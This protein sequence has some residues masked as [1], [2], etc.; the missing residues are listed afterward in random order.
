MAALYLGGFMQTV[1]LASDMSSI[2]LRTTVELAFT[3][4]RASDDIS[5]ID[6]RFCQVEKKTKGGPKRSTVT[7]WEELPHEYKFETIN[8]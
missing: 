7:L 5:M 6:W 8:W 1:E 4:L 3:P 2:M